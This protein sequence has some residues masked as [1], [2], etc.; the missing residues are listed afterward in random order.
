M[1]TFIPKILLVLPSPVATTQLLQ[2]TARAAK[3][4]VQTDK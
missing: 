4:C 3:K 2:R 1:S